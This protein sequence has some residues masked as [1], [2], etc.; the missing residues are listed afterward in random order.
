MGCSEIKRSDINPYATLGDKSRQHG[1]TAAGD[2]L[3][4]RLVSETSWTTIAINAQPST[5]SGLPA[6][7]QYSLADVFNLILNDSPPENQFTA[8]CDSGE[9]ID[10]RVESSFNPSDTIDSNPHWVSVSFQHR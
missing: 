8:D 3:V 2:L 9:E 5:F 6:S 7:R 4:W 1:F 10:A